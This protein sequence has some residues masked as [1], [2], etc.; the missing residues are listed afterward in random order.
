MKKSRCLKYEI[1]VFL[2]TLMAIIMFGLTFKNFMLYRKNIIKAGVIINMKKKPKVVTVKKIL[3]Y[4]AEQIHYLV[5]GSFNSIPTKITV[6]KKAGIFKVK[7]SS[8]KLSYPLL[9]RSFNKLSNL[10]SIRIDSACIG[11]DCGKNKVFVTFSLVVKNEV[12]ARN[13]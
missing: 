4:T 13:Y 10:F 2:L 3:P 12:N 6:V 1:T 7:V 11:Y 9:V 8:D 5:K